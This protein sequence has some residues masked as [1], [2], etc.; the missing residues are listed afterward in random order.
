MRMLLEFGWHVVF[1]G[2]CHGVH[3][4]AGRDASAVADAGAFSVV[5]EG[6]VEPLAREITSA[7]PIPT[8]GIGA[9]AECDGQVLVSEDMLG[10]FADFTP[11]FVRRY[12]NLGE[13]VSKAA[14]KY[15]GDV[16]ARRFPGPDN[17]FKES[18]KKQ[19]ASKSK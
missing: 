5:V 18:A 19:G 1:N 7:V 17:I 8:V 3:V 15:A 13:Q 11:K 10:L 9:S 6:V 14:A 16:K 12:A 4:F 2:A